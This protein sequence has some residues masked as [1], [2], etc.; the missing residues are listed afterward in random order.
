MEPLIYGA[1]EET[2]GINFDKQNNKFLMFGK[3]FPEE[4]KKF[5]T[6]IILWLEEYVASPND[7]T[8][9]ELRLDYYN[10]S[11]STVILEIFYILERIQKKGKEIKVIW[12][13]AEIDDDMLDSGKEYS[14]M[15]SIP[16]EFVPIAEY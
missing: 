4:S 14:K 16:F 8:L 7:K 3:S 5:F 9:F 12:N 13:Y 2:P 15:V 1:T 11:T 10:S 6:P